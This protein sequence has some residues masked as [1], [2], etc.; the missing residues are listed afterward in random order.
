MPILPECHMARLARSLGLLVMALGL[1]APPA[2]AADA[3]VLASGALRRCLG[4]TPGQ[5]KFTGMTAAGAASCQ[6][7][8][9]AA[10]YA[11]WYGRA[12]SVGEPAAQR[13]LGGYYEDGDGVAENWTWP[14]SS[15][16]RAPRTD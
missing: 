16:R 5:V 2:L 8:P 6:Q 4:I 10:L 3:V 13:E 7:L 11:C 1:G 15:T 12:A 9:G 14:R